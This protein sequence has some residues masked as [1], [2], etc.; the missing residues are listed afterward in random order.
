MTAND[1][2]CCGNCG[3][4]DD[5][6][7]CGYFVGTRPPGWCRF[8]E[9]DNRTSEQRKTIIDGLGNVGGIVSF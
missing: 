3:I 5:D 6:G 4:L 2:K 9:Y 1:L 8:W 7:Q